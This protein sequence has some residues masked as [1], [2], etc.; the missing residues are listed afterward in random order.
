LGEEKRKVEVED[1]D[2]NIVEAKVKAEL[3]TKTLCGEENLW[4]SQPWSEQKD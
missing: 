4:L 3:S 2:K 1:K